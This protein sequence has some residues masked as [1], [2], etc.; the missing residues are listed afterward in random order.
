MVSRT[1]CPVS[2]YYRNLKPSL[3]SLKE[4]NSMSHQFVT[5]QLTEEEVIVSVSSASEVNVTFSMSATV[6]DDFYVE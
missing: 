6:D 4:L 5:T 1:L 2:N 3:S